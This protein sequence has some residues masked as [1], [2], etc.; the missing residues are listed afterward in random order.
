VTGVVRHP[1]GPRLYVAGLRVHHGSAGVAIGML[2]L[3]RRDPLLGLAG[4]AMVIDDLSDFP[5]RDRDNHAP[6][7]AT[8]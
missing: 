1:W 8:G 6:A 7:E 2:G 5:W 3:A 4:L